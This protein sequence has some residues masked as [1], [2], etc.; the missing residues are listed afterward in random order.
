VLTATNMLLCSLPACFLFGSS[1]VGA[2]EHGSAVWGYGKLLPSLD[3]FGSMQGDVACVPWTDACPACRT[4]A[5]VVCVSECCCM[6]KQPVGQ[7]WGSHGTCTVFEHGL[8]NLQL[9]RP[10][11]V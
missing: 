10:A 5:E 8:P 3:A 4:F 2:N 9:Q 11:G 1:S 7:L 6:T